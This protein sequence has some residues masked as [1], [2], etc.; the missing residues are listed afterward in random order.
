MNPL[1]IVF[2]GPQGSGKGTQIAELRK[3]LQELD[4]A[5]KIV[6]IQTGRGFRGMTER[7]G[8][9]AE[10]KVVDSMNAGD[11]QPD[12]LTN[13]LWGQEM[14]AELDNESHLLIDGFPRNCAQANVLDEALRFF[15][16]NEVHVINLD[17][18]EEEVKK[19][20]LARGRADDTDE[21]IAH[22]LRQ[23][24]NET[25]PVLEFYR[26]RPH[27]TVHD[28]AGDGTVA[29]VQAQICAALNIA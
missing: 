15:E 21:S 6:E 9:F 25:I 28:I 26:N 16:R 24:Q 13:I 12:F 5:K 3:K 2:I 17:T 27:T 23:Y 22:R 4:G 18:P 8:T 1:T 14:L 19:R 20:M 10:K 7:Q 29:E 11:L